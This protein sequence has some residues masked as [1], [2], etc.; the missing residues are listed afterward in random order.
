MRLDKSAGA[1]S[2][3]LFASCRQRMSYVVGDE[4]LFE[5]RCLLNYNRHRVSNRTTPARMK[6]I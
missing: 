5:P 1:T 4:M 2:C 3:V 6:N